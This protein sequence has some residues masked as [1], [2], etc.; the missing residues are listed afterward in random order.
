MSR[1][2]IK[3][4]IGEVRAAFT[5]IELMIIMA[6]IAIM[7]TMSVTNFQAGQEDEAIRIDALRIAES[8][9][10]AQ[11]YAQSGIHQSYATARAYGVY[12]KKPSTIILFVDKTG[13]ADKVGVWDTA[14]QQNGDVKIGELISLTVGAKK[15][16]SID[17]QDGITLDGTPLDEVN[18]GFRALTASGLINGKSEGG[19]VTITLSS[20]RNNHTKKVTFNRL[21]G[22]V[23][24]EY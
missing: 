6:I 2:T 23:D 4:R 14:A 10:T 5:L 9:R 11:N 17:A 16:I 15:T 21:T 1:N 8:L 20:S 24:A 3:R 18:I 13:D 22:R 12:I 7:T 19:V